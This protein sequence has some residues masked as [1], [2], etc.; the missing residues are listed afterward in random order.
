MLTHEE[1]IS[2]T[3]IPSFEEQY[4][5]IRRAEQ[6]VYSDPLVRML[7]VIEPF[8]PHFAEWQQR[9]RSAIRISTY[10]SEK[11]NTGRIL[12]IGC[13]NGWLANLIATRTHHQV[14]ATDINSPELEQAMRVFHRNNLEFVIADGCEPIPGEQP[15]DYILFAASIQYFSSLSSIINSCMER[16]NPSGELHIMDTRFYKANAVAEARERTRIYYQS[17][18]YPQMLS[19]YFHHSLEELRAYHPDFLLNPSAFIN[20]L[21]GA[22]HEFPWIRIRKSKQKF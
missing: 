8:H 20:R 13:G 4:L 18:G 1:N 6:R 5:A 7:P 15:Y 12:E 2:L 9:S 21:T 17:L 14:I 11:A 10:L 16:L 3:T 22:Q 19:N